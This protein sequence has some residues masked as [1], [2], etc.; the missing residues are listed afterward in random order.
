M[1][2]YLGYFAAIFIGRSLGIMGGSGSILTVPL[3][4]YRVG[5]R[6]ILNTAYSS[7]W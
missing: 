6:L 2:Q 3:L 5:A 7:L 4:V 1:P